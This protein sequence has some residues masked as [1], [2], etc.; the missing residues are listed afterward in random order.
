MFKY[1]LKFLQQNKRKEEFINRLKD[2]NYGKTKI[3]FKDKNNLAIGTYI[4]VSNY[5]TNI[6]TTFLYANTNSWNVFDNSA[7][8]RGLGKKLK[9]IT[10]IDVEKFFAALQNRANTKNKIVITDHAQSLNINY[11]Y[12]NII[13]V[14]IKTIIILKK[15]KAKK[16]KE[17]L[18]CI[19]YGKN[20]HQKLYP[21]KY[22]DRGIGGKR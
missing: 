1:I 5:Q 12:K 17:F 2:P 6:T 11:N 18:A 13:T 14:A 15:Y 7:N 22:I 20:W 19:Q 10:T 8:P 4:I 3:K 9:Q 16:Q 21:H